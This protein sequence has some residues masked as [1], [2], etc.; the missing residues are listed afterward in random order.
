VGIVYFS[1][2]T[3]AITKSLFIQS[4][5]PQ[6][7]TIWQNSRDICLFGKSLENFQEMDLFTLVALSVSA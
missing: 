1:C 4:G 5:R 7:S 3:S 6:L 2:F